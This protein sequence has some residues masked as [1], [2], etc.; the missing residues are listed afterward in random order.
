M[1]LQILLVEDTPAFRENLM[2]T[3]RGTLGVDVV[4]VVEGEA[5][6]RA[7]LDEHKE[8]SVAIVDLLSRTVLDP[9]S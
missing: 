3:L 5:Q 6:A 8:W 9:G 7:W 4:K 2:E 1:N